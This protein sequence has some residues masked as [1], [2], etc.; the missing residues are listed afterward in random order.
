MSGACFEGEEGA[1]SLFDLTLALLGE[2][3][4][5]DCCVAGDVSDGDCSK[6]REN[7]DDGAVCEGVGGGVFAC[8]LAVE[9]DSWVCAKI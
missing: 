9:S 3:S 8:R 7:D 1:V 6:L 5:D 2:R 4:G